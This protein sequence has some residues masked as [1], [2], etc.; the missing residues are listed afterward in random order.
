[1]G[2]NDDQFIELVRSLVLPHYP[3]L[4]DDNIETKLSRNDKYLAI[5]ATIEATSKAQLDAIY[6]SLS[7]HPDVLIV[8]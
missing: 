5:T 2:R 6:Q 7:D 8:L 4:S 1:M 3:A